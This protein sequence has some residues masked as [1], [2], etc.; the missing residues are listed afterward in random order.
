MGVIAAMCDR[1][2][3]MRYG[4]FVEAG[5]VDDIFYAPKHDY[6]RM[7]LDAVPRLDQPDKPG[8]PKLPPVRGGDAAETLIEAKDVK[9]H[10]PI[11]MSGGLFGKTKPLKAVNG[12]S[13][14]A[15]PR[16]DAGRGGRSGCGKSTSAR[17]VL[18]LIEPREGSVVWLGKTDLMGLVADAR[19]AQDAQGSA[20]RPPGS[21]RL[22][23]SAHADRRF[24][25]RAAACSNLIS[26]AP[27][28]ATRCA[29]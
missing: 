29:R 17:A 25:R 12:V 3:V 10:F 1:V 27:K 26:A 28:C 21:A 22:A 24:D 11:R 6:T 14:Q 5:T 2:Q 19:D 15:S 8:H 9:V 7:L 16:R 13:F 23:R 4:E 20:D 18:Q